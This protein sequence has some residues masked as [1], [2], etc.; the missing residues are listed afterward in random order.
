MALVSARLR[1]C[2]GVATAVHVAALAFPGTAVA[3]AAP[4][5]ADFN[6]DGETNLTVGIPQAADVTVTGA[7]AA[8]IAPGSATGSNGETKTTVTQ[9]SLASG[10]DLPS[11]SKTG[12]AFGSATAWGD[13]NGDGMAVIDGATRTVKDTTPQE[14]ASSA[15]ALSLPS[16]QRDSTSPLYLSQPTAVTGGRVTAYYGSTTR[17]APARSTVIN[18]ES[19]DVPDGSEAGTGITGIGSEGQRIGTYGVPAGAHIGDVL[20]P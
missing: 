14:M 12:D 5:N 17:L 4:P 10:I 13:I 1:P 9:N 20:A 7:G 3:A 2:I 18:Q 16:A 15:G 19:T 6:Q 8:S 11:S